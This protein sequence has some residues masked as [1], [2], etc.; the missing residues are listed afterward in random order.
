MEGDKLNS[1]ILIET[2]LVKKMDFD[3]II[4]DFV[5]QKSRRKLMSTRH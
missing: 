5:T 1:L 4:D 3:A 2:E